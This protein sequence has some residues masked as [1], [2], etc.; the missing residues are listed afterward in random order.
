MTNPAATV[1]ECDWRAVQHLKHT[2]TSADKVGRGI[3]QRAI[4]IKNNALER[5]RVKHNEGQSS[6]SVASAAHAGP[7]GTSTMRARSRWPRRGD[8]ALRCD[9]IVEPCPKVALGVMKLKPWVDAAIKESKPRAS[10]KAAASQRSGRPST[11]LRKVDLEGNHDL[12][13]EHYVTINKIRQDGGY[14]GRINPIQAIL[15]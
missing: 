15:R 12:L 5:A 10:S 4:E 1:L 11:L 2:V 8:G 6:D 3:D 7:L 14:I 9:L 13:V